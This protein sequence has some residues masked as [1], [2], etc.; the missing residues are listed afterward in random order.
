MRRTAQYTGFYRVARLALMIMVAPLSGHTYL[1]YEIEFDKALEGARVKLEVR[2]SGQVLPDRER[3]ARLRDITDCKGRPVSAAQFQRALGTGLECVAYGLQLPALPKGRFQVVLPH[4][5]AVFDPNQIIFLR[6]G[7]SAK[8]S[9]VGNVPVSHPW[10]SQNGELWVDPSPR[11]STAQVVLGAFHEVEVAG[12]SKPGAFVG[13]QRH[14]PKLSTWLGEIVAQA[15][16][17]YPFPNPNL[18]IMMFEV[19]QKG[20]SPVPFGHVIRNQGESVRLFVDAE[21]SLADLRRDW[22]VAHELAHLKLPYVSGSGRWISEGFASYYQNVLQARIGHYTEVEAWQRMTGSFERAAEVGRDMS[23]NGSTER[24]FWKARLMI[25]WSGA[26]LAL[27]ID[28][29][30][31]Q[32]GSSLDAALAT[33]TLPSRRGWDTE[34]LFAQLDRNTGFDVFTRL[35]LEHGDRVGMPDTGEVLTALGIV[36]TGDGV[37]LSNSARLSEI[38]QKIMAPTALHLAQ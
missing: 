22:T 31:R 13:A 37:S 3:V 6:G 14:V 21:A 24:P 9:L 35:Y 27:L 23:P 33:L 15:G 30:L 25:Y 20:P 12:L 11:S 8:V 32:L 36:G 17:G 29:E 34:Q 38:R 18:Q 5:V 10:R 2:S 4:N 1:S 28:S 19:P 7:E 26:A 16:T